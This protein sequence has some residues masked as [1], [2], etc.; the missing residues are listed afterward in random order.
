[1]TRLWLRWL[2]AAAV[3]VVIAAGALG[4]SFQ[5]SAAEG[6]STKT[7]EQVL[8]MVGMNTVKALSGTVEQ[9]SD[10]GLPQLPPGV[11]SSSAGM[12]SA[13]DLL[14]APHTARVYLDGT[15][16]ARVQVMD[17]LAE[18]D[19]IR[20]GNDV[21]TYNSKDNSAT[22]E[23]LPTARADGNNAPATTQLQTPDQLAQRMLAALDSSTAVTVGQDTSVAGRAAYELLLTPR[24]ADSLVG[25]V[26]IAVD[27][28][29]GL[30]LS[31]AVQARGQETPAF[32]L[33][34]TDLSLHA[35]SADLFTFTPPP[36]A[37]VT[38]RALPQQADRPL[39]G[40]PGRTGGNSGSAAAPHTVSGTGWD[41]V[42]GLPATAVPADL[43]ASPLL[44]QAARAVDGGRLLSTSL[45]NVLLTNDG[46]VFA[47][48]VPLARLQA[49]AAGR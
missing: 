34:F 32:R 24:S 10:L 27:S 44:A 9:T 17:Q 14:A 38:Q 12:A 13:L 30:T 7:P 1:M 19:V 37:H 35:P 2:P 11:P 45:V 36:G 15:A 6:L 39:Q 46:R 31:V 40:E 3:P 4:G 47:G 29:T 41:T 25:S 28:Q 5:A 33:A 49:A 42:I 20:H 26:S 21:W 8:A 43:T 16:N 22:H 18:R 23:T 48:S